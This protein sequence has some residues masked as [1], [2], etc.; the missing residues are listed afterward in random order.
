[1]DVQQVRTRTDKGR[2]V[3]FVRSTVFHGYNIFYNIQTPEIFCAI[4]IPAVR[5][6]LA[7]TYFRS[8]SK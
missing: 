2:A 4:R 5:W 7:K 1:M 6:S 3:C 8:A